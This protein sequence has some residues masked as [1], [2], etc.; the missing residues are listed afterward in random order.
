[1]DGW[2][3]LIVAIKC[4]VILLIFLG[5]PL[6]LVLVERWTLGRLQS[7]IEAAQE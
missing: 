1:M 6:I 7:R 3:W 4:V 5:A 2:E